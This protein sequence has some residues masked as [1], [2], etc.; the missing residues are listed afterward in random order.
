MLLIDIYLIAPGEQD[1]FNI[2]VVAGWRHF[3][4]DGLDDHG[5]VGKV[6]HGVTPE[7]ANKVQGKRVKIKVRQKTH[8]KS[9]K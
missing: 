4:D 5:A 7:H 3:E 6:L 9:T 2:G 8:K 1:N